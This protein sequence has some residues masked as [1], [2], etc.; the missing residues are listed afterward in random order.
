MQGIRTALEQGT[1]EQFVSDFYAQRTHS[2][3]VD[4]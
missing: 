4:A 3:A 2:T 1:F